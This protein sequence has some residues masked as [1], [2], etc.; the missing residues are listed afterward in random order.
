MQEQFLMDCLA[1]EKI[2]CVGLLWLLLVGVCL[3]LGLFGF[4]P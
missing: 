4:F 1:Q 3:F 2:M